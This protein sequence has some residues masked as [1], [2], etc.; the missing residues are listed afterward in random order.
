MIIFNR[1]IN[2][3]RI[4]KQIIVLIND[5]VI[6]IISTYLAF[7]LRLDSLFISFF[8]YWKVFVIGIVTFTPFFI[9]LGLYQAIFRYTGFNYLKNIF[10]AISFYGV[11]FFS[12]IILS[13]FDGVP[14]SIGIL[15][16]LV[17]F[18]LIVSS[19]VA[20]S[21]IILRYY[22]LKSN[23]KKV[24]I[25]GAG[26]AGV[27]SSR[28]LNN[29]EI[30]GFIDDDSRKW[31]MKINNF[32]VF[33]FNEI[34]YL[35]TKKNIN[36]ILIA[37]PSLGL[38]NRRI[39][40]NKLQKFSIEVKIL[41]GINQYISGKVSVSD[42]KKVDPMELIERNI[43][44]NK[45]RLYNEINNKILLITG[46]GGSIGSELTRQIIE[47]N[48]RKIIIIDHTEYNLFK[49]LSELNILKKNQ[50]I[51]IPIID[52]LC[53][54]K[55]KNKIKDIIF[56]YKPDYIFHAAAYKHVPLLENNS[57]EA[58][59]NNIIGTLNLVQASLEN[60]CEKFIFISTDKAVRPTNIMGATKRFAEIILQSYT[61]EYLKDSKT[62]FSIV[63]FGNVLNSSGSVIPLFNKQIENLGPITVTDPEV[64]RYFMSTNEAVGLI[65]YSTTLA[66]GG[67]VF[68]LDMGK[69]LKII[70]LAKKMVKLS[71]LTEKNSS[72]PNGDIEIKFIGLRDGEKLHEELVIGSN[73]QNTENEYIFKS[74]ENHLSFSMMNNYIKE[75]EFAIEKNNEKEIISI[76]KNSIDGFIHK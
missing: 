6:S 3:P 25:Y 74:H 21:V 37:I 8:D 70:D 54:I 33:S 73:I 1:L 65:L 57:I 14:R 60:K 11:V 24:L 51:N 48:P 34:D 32:K 76:L 62:I 67:E 46:A 59:K 63:R 30:I 47:L 56:K 66:K 18:I 71:G 75:F 69:P 28:I 72:N 43:T 4:Q 26:E 31:G 10:F 2:L 53:S 55:D 40:V 42:F 49:I 16:P 19:R 5:F 36:S 41:P 20:I 50:N 64:T 52:I 22:N 27:Q 58:V 7:A 13:K 39:L 29:Y 38:I 23:L 61:S 17:F 9:P 44:W 68:I 12:I 35:L 15:Q 45:D